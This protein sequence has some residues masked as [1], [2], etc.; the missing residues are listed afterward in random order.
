[1]KETLPLNKFAETIAQHTGHTPADVERVLGEYILLLSERLATT[2]TTSI[3]GIGDLNFSFI[4]ERK[5]LLRPDEQLAKKLNEPFDIFE[6]VEIDPDFPIE[7]L[8]SKADN[9]AVG[10]IYET[11]EPGKNIPND[12]GV[13]PTVSDTE[14]APEQLNEHNAY[15]PDTASEDSSAAIPTDKQNQTEFTPPIPPIAGTNNRPRQIL[16]LIIG[17]LTGFIAGMML[18]DPLKAAFNT[19]DSKSIE[20][21][22]DSVYISPHSSIH[23][24]EEEQ[25]PEAEPQTE[26]KTEITVETVRPGYDI[27]HMAKKYYGSK[28][29]WVYIYDAN[30]DLPSNPNHIQPGMDVIIPSI[31]SLGV[32]LN[33][34][35]TMAS[36]RKRASEIYGSLQ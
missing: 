11:N 34:P 2:G 16:W 23:V 4:G 12:S 8:N 31:S 5:I 15:R 14:Y 30:P 35:E 22:S 13:S 29:F 26:P 3:D 33:S 19:D 21:V 32:D 18:H 6:P 17:L 24:T 36:A 27:T 28:L 9:D 1:M 20:T 7:L 25:P 10:V